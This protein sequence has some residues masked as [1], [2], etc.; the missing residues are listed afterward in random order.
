[1]SPRPFPILIYASS[2]ESPK[3][4]LAE[5]KLAF[6]WLSAHACV[7]TDDNLREV[8]VLHFRA[9]LGSA[10][11]QAGLQHGRDDVFAGGQLEFEPAILICFLAGDYGFVDLGF[12]GNSHV[13][14]R[15]RVGF[16]GARNGA[17][18]PPFHDASDAA[19]C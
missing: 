3:G 10:E 5:Q 2:R 7:V 14:Q 9:L 15:H 4:F 18:R 16:S 13:G 17:H 11:A 8:L 6:R 1:M 12:Y 19:S